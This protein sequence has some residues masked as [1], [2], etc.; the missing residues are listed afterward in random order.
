MGFGRSRLFPNACSSLR[1][2]A[3]L[4]VVDESCGTDA[5]DELAVELDDNSKTTT[6]T[7][8]PS[9]MELFSHFWSDNTGPLI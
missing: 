9:C 7:I 2:L 3:G 5:E 6:S 8:F 4:E 1:E